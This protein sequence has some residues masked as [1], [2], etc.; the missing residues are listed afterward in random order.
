M[1]KWTAAELPD[2]TGRTAVVTGASSGI[3]LVTARELARVGA[4]VVLAVRDVDKGRA[5][6]AAMEGRTEVRQLDVADLTSVRAFAEGWSGPLDVLIN[7]AG[8]GLVPLARTAD[9]FESQLATN[10]LGPFVL[11][12]L[13]LPHITDRVVMVS[14]QLHR[15]GHAHLDDLNFEVRRYRTFA[16]YGDSKL[17]DALFAL[18][19]QRR[20]TA[21]GSLVRSV[22][23]HPGVAITN[24]ASHRRELSVANRLMGFMFNDADHG[25]LP[26]LFAATQDIPG[27]SY[28][29]PHGPAGIKGYP[30]V[31]TPSRAARDADTARRLWDLTASMTG[32]DTAQSVH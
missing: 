30:K 4:K 32:I 22:I 17:Y 24:F 18:E 27:G 1:N 11:T 14:S 9:G 2:L 6:A 31:A 16:A 21:S 29:G 20:L 5:A 23:A 15:R 13:L 12:S 28:V 3:G 19:L 10:Y 7:N 26:T 25:A 8:I